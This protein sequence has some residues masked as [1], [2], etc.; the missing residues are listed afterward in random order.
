VTAGVSVDQ[1]RPSYEGLAELYPQVKD[2]MA[3]VVRDNRRAN[4]R[5]QVRTAMGK[6]LYVNRGKE[7]AGVDYTI[8]G[9][10]A[11][12]LKAGTV[13][14]DAAGYGPMLRLTIHDEIFA[15]VPVADAQDVLRAGSEILTD[16]VNWAVPLTWSGTILEERWVKS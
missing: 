9:T 4:H 5:P 11:E 13:A 10:A 12:I 1:M 6:R 8:Q 2:F 15:E 14:M 3:K 16:R 7:Y